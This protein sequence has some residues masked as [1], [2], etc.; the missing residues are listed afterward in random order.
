[1]E[2]PMKR[3]RSAS[4][5]MASASLIW[6][7]ALAASNGPPDHT[8][9]TPATVLPRPAAPYKGTL[10]RTIQTFS[11]PAYDMGVKAPDQAPNILLIMTDDVGFGASSTFG[12]PVPTATFDAL[13]ASGERYNA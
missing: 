13:A 10:G 1:M 5:L 8:K 11:P 12:G 2:V 9:Y 3:M 6:T 7:A 4:L